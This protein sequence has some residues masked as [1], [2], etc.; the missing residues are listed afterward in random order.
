MR[1]G[2]SGVLREREQKRLEAMPT[3]KGRFGA[4]PSF[5]YGVQARELLHSFPGAAG[6]ASDAE[7]LTKPM[8]GH[9]LVPDWQVADAAKKAA[10]A[11]V[12]RE[13]V[14]FHTQRIEAAAAA[15]QL[16]AETT[17]DARMESLIRQGERYFGSVANENRA[18]LKVQATFRHTDKADAMANPLAAL[19]SPRGR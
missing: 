15:R 12:R 16:K 17:H 18:K 9:Q 11:K 14:R 3:T 19:T 2:T 8:V 13:Q 7:R 4:T 5:S 6:Y 10:R 1:K